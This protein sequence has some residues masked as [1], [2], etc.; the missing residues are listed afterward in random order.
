MVRWTRW[1]AFFRRAGW[2]PWA[3]LCV[4][5]PVGGA[6][7]ADEEATARP[8]AF[9]HRAA[10]MQPAIKG[11]GLDRRQQCIAK[12]LDWLRAHQSPSGQWEARGFGGW[13]DGTRRTVEASAKHGSG[14]ATHDVGVTGLALQALLAAGYSPKSQ[15]S[16]GTAVARGVAWLVARQDDEGCFAARTGHGWMYSHATATIAVVEAYGMAPSASLA[17]SAQRALDFIAAAR[18]PKLAWRYGVRPGKNDT[19]IS[20]WMT[21]ALLSAQEVNTALATTATPRPLRIDPHAIDGML[22]WLDEVTD[23]LS[24]RVGYLVRGSGP[25]RSPRLAKAFPSRRS[26]SLTSIGVFVR[27][28][29]A[30]DSQ[31]EARL[32][33]GLA[34]IAKRRPRWR[35]GGSIDMHS[36]YWGS[37]ATYQVGGRAWQGWRTALLAAVCA[38]QR[39]DGDVCSYRGSWDPIGPW[40]AEGGRV[41][42]TSLLC[43]CLLTETRYAR[44]RP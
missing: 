20:G 39:S 17:R 12:G 6:A 30:E 25:A 9:P 38:N 44:R 15:G 19:S 26:A 3:L 43:L 32:T 27:S 7:S 36:W 37:L 8:A 33:Q 31:H 40:G 34:W 22:H 5:L 29:T 24:G 4:L 18:N 14:E 41:Y 10:A 23:P 1:G 21:L 13:C 2:L 28:K 35:P 42:A 16:Y 11:G